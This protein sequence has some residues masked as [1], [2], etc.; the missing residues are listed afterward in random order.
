MKYNEIEI[1]MKLNIHFQI[2]VNLQRHP[3]SQFSQETYLIF[4]YMVDHRLQH[5][6]I[7]K[8]HVLETYKVFAQEILKL[9]HRCEK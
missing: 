7:A 3:F 5:S 1:W 4:R 8:V 6:A 9:Q 2:F